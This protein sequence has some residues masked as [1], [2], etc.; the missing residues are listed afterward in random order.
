VPDEFFRTENGLEFYGQASF[1]KAGIA[2]ADRL[3]TVSPTYATEIQ[4]P[5]YGAGLH[6][7]LSFRRRTLHGILNGIDTSAWN[8]GTDPLIPARYSART[9]GPKAD[10]R[11]AL[12]QRTGLDGGG[13]VLGMVTRIAHQKGIDIL[14]AAVPGVV[15]RGCSLVLLGDGDPG[16]VHAL[17]S[18][19]AECPTGWPSSRV[20]MSRWPT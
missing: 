5:A 9:P 11:A 10:N 3:A 15:R 16:F 19:A 1:M 17:E 7:L 14:L 12:L 18:V 20:S 6:G 8:P 13:P 2:I 4:T